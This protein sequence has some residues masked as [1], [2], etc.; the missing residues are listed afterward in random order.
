MFWMISSTDT[1]LNWAT[2]E[3]VVLLQ[4]FHDDKH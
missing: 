2:P 4:L 3:W 1:A